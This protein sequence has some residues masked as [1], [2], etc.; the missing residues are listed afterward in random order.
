M[1]VGAAAE[2]QLSALEKAYLDVVRRL[3]AASAQRSSFDAASE[4]ATAAAS[5]A[6]QG[7]TEIIRSGHE[8][9]QSSSMCTYLHV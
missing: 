7:E 6:V 9:P 8:N 5:S 4:F 1:D 2:Q 3:N